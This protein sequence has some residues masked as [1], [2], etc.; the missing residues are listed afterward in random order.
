[1]LASGRLVEHVGWADHV[2]VVAPLTEQTR[3]LVDAAV[4]GAMKPTAHL[5][6]LGR[7]PIVDEHALVDA[8][9]GRDIA[10][11]SLDVFG[12]EPLPADH[13][14]WT[15]PGVAISPHLSGDASGFRDVLA[16]QFVDNAMRFLDGAPLDNVV[17]KRLGFVPTPSSTPAGT[18]S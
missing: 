6:N 16:R 2:V 14:L 11:A 3:G 1:V 8:L 10:A 12:V 18:R 13:P 7:G 4:L 9:G 15:T 5:V 17:D